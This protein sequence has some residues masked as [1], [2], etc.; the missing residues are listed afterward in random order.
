MSKL[1]KILAATDLSPRGDKA[2]ARAAHL[3][4]EHNANLAILYV[5]EQRA[6]DK[7][8][9]EKVAGLIEKGLREKITAWSLDAPA[10]TLVNGK[11]SIEIIRRA[12]HAEADLIVAGNHGVNLLADLIR[13]GT[14]ERLVRQGDRP[15]LVVKRTARG[16]YRR[17]LVPVDFSEHSR[18]VLEYARWLEPDA[19]FHVLHAY[20]GIERQLWRTDLR[21]SEIMRYQ[22]ESAKHAGQAMKAFLDRIDGKSNKLRPEIGFG[23]APHVISMVSNRLCPDLVVIGNTGRRGLPHLLLGSV[24]QHVMREVQCDVLVVPS[25]RTRMDL[26]SNSRRAA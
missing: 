18:G 12:R 25:V 26:E 19:E 7:A 21:K 2:L 17:V 6:G 9:M 14:A 5:Q 24:T 8:K 16:P 10:I 22:R 23:R 1:K 3:A 13:P 15:V 20:E 4:R 11:P